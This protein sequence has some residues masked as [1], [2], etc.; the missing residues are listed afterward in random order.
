ML[1]V[2]QLVGALHPLVRRG[3][4]A[5]L[6]VLAASAEDAHSPVKIIATLR[7]DHYDRPMRHRAFGEPL[8]HAT[9]LITPM[10]VAELE[11]ATVAPAAAAG[12]TFEAGLVPEIVTDVMGQASALPLLQ[13]ALTDFFEHVA[14]VPRSMLPRM[15]GSAA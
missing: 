12:V 5:F 10:S 15:P 4:R 1:V 8:R 11:Q 7:A 2:D 9:E 13:P 6:D 14:S 3:S